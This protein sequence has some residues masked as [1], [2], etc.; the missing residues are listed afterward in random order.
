MPPRTGRYSRLTHGSVPEP[1]FDSYSVDEAIDHIGLGPF[2]Y[3]V[4]VLA[5][6]CWTAESME[7]LLLSF[8]KQPL[9]CEW[10]ITDPQAALITTIVAVGML[11][12]STSWGM[13]ADRFG[14]RT[15]FLSSTAFV[16]FM[17][18][19]SAVSVNYYMLLVARG[20]VGFG[21]G[22]IP[23]SF[24][25]LMEF[26]PSAQRGSW[27]MSLALFWAIGAM[28]E[29]TVAMFVLPS[30][31][32]RWL[33]AVSTFPL[34]LVLLMSFYLSESPRWLAA[35][36]Q[37][38]QVLHTL[39]HI[40]KINGGRLPTGRL[41]IDKLKS[42]DNNNEGHDVRSANETVMEH[43]PDASEVEGEEQFTSR[44]A[45]LSSQVSPQNADHFSNADVA[46]DAAVNGVEDYSELRHRVE[47][48]VDD[49][50]SGE[51]GLINTERP[52]GLASLLRRGARSLAL[53]LLLIWFACAFVYYGLVMLQPEVI[54]AENEGIRCAY[55]KS[56]CAASAEKDL[57]AAEPI[58]SW[59]MDEKCIP[60]GVLHGRES[61]QPD[62]LKG[63]CARKLSRD[64]FI[65]TFWASTGEMPGVLFA[66]VLV[67]IIGRRPLVGYMFASLCVSFIMLMFC[68]SRMLETAV[69]FVARG[70]SSGA[71]QAM[72]LLTNEIYPA[73]IR[74]TAMGIASS[75]SRVGLLITPFIAQWLMNI[76]ELVALVAYF[77]SALLA[78]FCVMLLPIETTGRPLVSSMDDLVQALREAHLSEDSVGPS[79]SKDPSVHPLVRFFRWN[80]VL[81]GITVR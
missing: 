36:G 41:A 19:V 52:K 72:Y 23:V 25:L 31:G 79:F 61:D 43:N 16:F 27:G 51:G 33:I 9:Q 76:D 59:T 30:L 62:P 15:S 81:D 57:C 45:L 32:W 28:F 38:D 66:F 55:A 35:R 46:S 17:G 7:M 63:I 14:R 6:L 18:I 54:A 53:K 2:Q 4:L 20:L 40:A 1:M 78:M 71:F 49:M 65:A 48:V 47:E 26:L 29:S 11:A 68:T 8:I 3:I 67:D 70:A 44:D 42:D 5:G 75:T 58:C 64:D 39:E 50:E 60:T 12:G 80:A 21:I 37:H 74:A 73:S 77:V 56:E 24:S 13:F 69:F 10:R 22:G 34:L